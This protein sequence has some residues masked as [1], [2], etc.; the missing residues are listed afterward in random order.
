VTVVDRDQLVMALAAVFAGLTVL[1]VVMTL[2]FKQ[3]LLLFVAIPFGATTY[4]MW[5]QASGRMQASFESAGRRRANTDGGF[6]A[7]A[8]RE[9]RRDRRRRDAR[10]RGRRRAAPET[11]DRPTRAEALATLGLDDDAGDDEVRRAYRDRVK[12]VH[13]DRGG[14]EE[15]FKRVTRAYDRLSE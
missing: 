10:E 5:Y 6:G 4:F 2:A 12:E 1:L 7:G 9:A 15:A 8:R 14:D 11:T 3:P 13:P